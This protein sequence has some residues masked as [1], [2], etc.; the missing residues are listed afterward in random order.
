MKC[1]CGD[2]C[3][4]VVE[5]IC[6]NGDC[7]KNYVLLFTAKWC[8][9]CPRMKLVAEQLRQEGYIVYVVDFDD[10]GDR[11]APLKITHLPTTLVFD[12]GKETKRFVGVASI[13]DIK[14]GLKKK[15]EQPDKKPVPLN[16]YNFK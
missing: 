16:P 5:D 13:E 15:S 2:E 14:D 9:A 8:R 1:S 4:C 3:H 7:K 10:I 6:K 11:I 12:D